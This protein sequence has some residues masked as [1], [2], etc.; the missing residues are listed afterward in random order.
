MNIGI[1]CEYNPFHYG[2]LYHLNKIKEMYP[3]DE[4]I[5]VISSHFLQRGET[6]LINKWKKTEIREN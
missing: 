6:S 4:I 1:I 3:N 2:H 5:L